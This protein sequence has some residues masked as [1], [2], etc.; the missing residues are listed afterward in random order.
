MDRLRSMD[1]ADSVLAVENVHLNAAAQFFVFLARGLVVRS[2]VSP[3]IS[4]EPLQELGHLLAEAVHRL[5]IH[6][7]LCNHL[8]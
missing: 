7:G 8:W 4:V 1:G 5:A 3:G 6:V 2:E